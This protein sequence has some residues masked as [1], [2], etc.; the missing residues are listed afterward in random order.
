MF[1]S[2]GTYRGCGGDKDLKIG[3]YGG[4]FNPIHKGHVAVIEYVLE[5]LPLD[6][7]LIIPVGVPS[8]RENDLADAEIRYEMCR[9]ALAGF[10]KTEVSRIEIESGKPAYTFDTM[11][12]LEKLYPEGEFYLIIGED[13]AQNISTWK[14]YS[15][16]LENYHIVVLRRKGYVSKIQ[17][18]K[19]MELDMPY[20]NISST[21][22][23]EKIK[24]GEDV[25]KFVP[26]AVL[27]IIIRK[28]LYRGN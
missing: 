13:S 10:L 19:L 5:R 14:N 28:K 1:G 2:A 20:F 12:K 11:K 3:V 8:H 27:E 6:K 21:E 4:S 16:L 22:I 25:S 15:Y 9:E 24:K 23:R 17:S 18:N 26:E 7:L